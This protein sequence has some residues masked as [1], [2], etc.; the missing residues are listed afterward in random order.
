MNA[1]V[2]A[3]LVRGMMAKMVKRNACKST[4]K[5]RN[6]SEDL[7][8]AARGTMLRWEEKTNDACSEDSSQ[9]ENGGLLQQA[10]LSS[11]KI[12]LAP[13]PIATKLKRK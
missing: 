1:V 8:P 6:G 7:D 9:K 5:A 4:R 10:P 12:T 3:S 13:E 11:E 2:P